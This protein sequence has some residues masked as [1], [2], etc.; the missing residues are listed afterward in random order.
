MK[1]VDTIT[2]AELS[3]MAQKMYGNFVKGVV[4]LNKK[5]LVVDVEMHADA[6]Q[7]LL[8]KGSV[9]NDLWGINLYPSKFKTDEFI[10]FDSMINI[11]PRQ[12]NMS[13]GIEDENIRKQITLLVVEKV[14]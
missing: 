5:I 12:N 8:E 2:V 9:Q 13:R 1:Q 11:R 6:E 10:E 14:K 4:D 3:E 7:F